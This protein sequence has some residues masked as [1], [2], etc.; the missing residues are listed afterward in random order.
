MAEK[1]PFLPIFEGETGELSQQ[2]AKK[3]KEHRVLRQVQRLEWEEPED[4]LHV[5]EPGREGPYGHWDHLIRGSKVD[6]V[7]TRY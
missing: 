3:E 5:D 7:E 2:A 6:N 1:E 4:L